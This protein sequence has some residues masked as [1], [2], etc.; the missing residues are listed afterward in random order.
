MASTYWDIR[1]TANMNVALGKIIENIRDKLVKRPDKATVTFVSQSNLQGVFRSEVNVRDHVFQVD[2]PPPMGGDNAGPN[3][4]ELTLAALGTCQEMTYRLC[5]TAMG[6]EIARVS[7][8][9]E[10]DLDMRGLF[11]VDDAVRPGL[12]KVRLTI[13]LESNASPAE[14]EEL[15]CHVNAH[16]PVLDILRNPVPVEVA[17]VAN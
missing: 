17:Y 14:L 10:G 15:K 1:E 7:A 13:T 3:P 2:E 6:I 16:C 8:K 4:V 12:Q 9:V 11:A 5:A